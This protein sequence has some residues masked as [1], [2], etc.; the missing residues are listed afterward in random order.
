[1]EIGRQ[2][3]SVLLVLALLAAALWV[4]RR[5]TSASFLSVRLRRPMG[6]AKA[7]QTIERLALS[8]H[9]SLHLVQIDGRRL[10]VATHPQGCS[11]L[12]EMAR[13]AGA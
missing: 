1:M 7:L 3:L 4:I 12:T 9:H 13:G 6:R 11:L 2:V 5:A 10:V 8:P